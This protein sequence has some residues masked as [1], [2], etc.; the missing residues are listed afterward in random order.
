MTLPIFT[1]SD[2]PGPSFAELLRRVRPTDSLP[3]VREALTITHGTTVVAI[4]Y[5][6]GVLM[7]GDRRATPGNPIPPRTKE[8]VFPADRYSGRAT[9]GG[10]GAGKGAVR[11]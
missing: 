11:G 10:A 4:R 5:A 2:D 6:A 3:D 1:A 7:A 8:Q 9:P